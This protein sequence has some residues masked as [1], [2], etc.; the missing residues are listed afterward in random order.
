VI[1]NR[2]GE[3]TEA[4]VSNIAFVRSGEI[5]TPPRSAGLLRGI[6]REFLLNEIATRVGCPVRETSLRP[7]DLD[8]MDE[9][10]LLSTT[11]DI[12]PVASIDAHRFAVGEDTLTWRIKAAFAVLARDYADAHPELRV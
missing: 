3:L 6:T 7:Q 10:F 8:G 12:T 11:K 2:A 9:C 1:T 5:I 4:A